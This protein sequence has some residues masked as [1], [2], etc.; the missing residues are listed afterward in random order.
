MSFGAAKRRPG[1]EKHWPLWGQIT[2]ALLAALI[3]VNLATAWLIRHVESDYLFAKM[4]EKSRDS[5]TLLA[6]T[7]IGAVITEDRPALDTIISQSLH[8]A[9]NMVELAIENENGEILARRAGDVP[10]AKRRVRRYRYPI[11][12]EGET[13][14]Y[15]SIYWNIEPIYAE[16]EL[17]VAKVRTFASVVLIVLTGLIVVLVDWLAIRPIRRISDYLMALSQGR[18]PAPLNLSASR[19][20]TY[21]AESAN[22]ISKALLQ[23]DQ[24]EQELLRIRRKL[25]EAHDAALAASRAKSG[26][27]A[28]M[29][30]EIRTP[31]NAVLGILGLLKD[32]GPTTEQEHL[33]R[34][35]R[36]SGELLL[37]VI[38]D[39]LDFSKMEADKVSL[40]SSGFN[41]HRVVASTVELLKNQAQKKGLSLVLILAPNLPAHVRGDADRL[42]QILVNL[43]NNAI[44]FTPAGEI[45]VRAGI[46]VGEGDGI[47]FRCEVEDTGIGIKNGLQESL[48][49]EFTMGDISHSRNHNGTGLG[50]A[51]SKRLV[52]LM[53]G[54]I[55]Y[56]SEPGLGSTF[57]F[58]VEL[59][60]ETTTEPEGDRMQ[61]TAMPPL[62]ENTRIL[63]AEDNPANQMVVKKI[64]EYAGL[65]HVDVASN[66][67]EAVEAV[68][69][70]PYDIVL[71]DMSMPVMDGMQATG[72]IR[73]LDD[74]CSRV[75]II[76]LTAHALSG[77]KDR[78]LE[79]GV[80]DYL[81]KPID[82]ADILRCISRWTEQKARS[83][84]PED[85]GDPPGRNVEIPL[86][87]ESVLRQ[88][89]IDT[90]PEVVPELLE[91]YAKD[92]RHRLSAI[93][94]AMNEQDIKTLEFEVHTV[95]SSAGAHG[96]SRLHA[97]AREIESLCREGDSVQAFT[98]AR[99]LPSLV[100]DS[101]R[102][103]VKDSH[104]G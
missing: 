35:G 83:R 59:E 65:R 77:D 68:R 23:R 29:S 22:D 18:Q 88:L 69:S 100:D 37:S 54:E 60:P 7:A 75:P 103:L 53:D 10:T 19:E 3:V 93:H 25:T 14:G 92:T 39:I 90:A 27:L 47:R 63:L 8:L 73:Q 56:E 49:D 24:R 85:A 51:I 46:A 45:T 61:E 70:L 74:S 91:L 104:T 15:M 9:P 36:D 11:E 16:V 4:E 82:K 30:H 81:T 40:D 96:N 97:M 55:D 64:L 72:E 38:N 80:D 94:T 20:L 26:F 50:L 34:T 62:A 48:F 95:G 58:E 6:A 52:T 13:F 101:L 79:A 67:R 87:D 5:S 102:A 78:F 31:L 33:I 44:K 84:P 21:L 1:R 17:H 32:S 98:T 57:W 12:L 41:L 89:E 76:A 28:A 71:M 86:V 42:R 2:C 99:A 43:I 66:G